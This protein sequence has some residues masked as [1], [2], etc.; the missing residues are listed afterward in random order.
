MLS[1][2][3]GNTMQGLQMNT[4]KA[5]HLPSDHPD[6][7]G[8]KEVPSIN[9]NSAKLAQKRYQKD[10]GDGEKAMAPVHERLFNQ[11]L[12][13]DQLANKMAMEVTTEQT[14]KQEYLQKTFTAHRKSAVSNNNAAGNRIYTKGIKLR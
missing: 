7:Q 12:I 3:M 4:R 8:V 9:F 10:L 6:M 2:S 1:P 13:K 11:T 14:R 5:L